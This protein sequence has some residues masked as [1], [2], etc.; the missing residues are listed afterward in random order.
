MKLGNQGTSVG[1]NDSLGKEWIH[2]INLGIKIMI[3]LVLKWVIFL[4]W[5][6]N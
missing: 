6:L 3:I 5:N 1:M 2:V 4:G